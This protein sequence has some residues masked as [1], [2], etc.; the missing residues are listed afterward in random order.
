MVKTFIIDSQGNLI[1]ASKVW[2]DFAATIP[3]IR[4]FSLGSNFPPQYPLF[5]GFP[6]KYHFVFYAFVGFFEK[7]GF[8]LDWALNIPSTISFFVLLILIYVF[9]KKV[10]QKREVGILAIILFLFNGSLSFI[11]FF[12]INPLSINSFSDIISNSKFPSFAPYD[13]KIITAFWNLNIY[14]NQRHLA[15]SFLGFLLLTLIIF[16]SNK[17]ADNKNLKIYLVGFFVGIFPFVHLAVFGAMSIA[18]LIFFLIYPKIR[19]QLFISGL[20]TIIIAVPQLLYMKSSIISIEFLNPGFLIEEL[21]FGNF[22][23]YWFLNLGAYIILIPLSL[24]FINKE[25]R[26]IFIPFMSLFI[27]ANF[28][29][30]SREIA[31]NHKLFNIFLIGGNILVANLLVNIHSKN[32]LG[33]IIVFILFPFLILSGLIDLFPILND[34][35]LKI[36]DYPKDKRIDFINEYTPKDSVFLNTQ[37]LYDPASLAGRKIYLGW[38]YFSWSAGYYTN[39]RHSLM[40][41]MFSA[42]DEEAL[43]SL[44]I[45]ENIDYIEIQ[46]PNGLEEVNINYSY[47][48]ENFARIYHDKEIN[49]AIYDVGISCNNVK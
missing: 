33:K 43:C 45:G 37:F 1:I 11:E 34:K 4:S 49:Y 38:P 10:F 18:L 15:F 9:S 26:K 16:L 48:R 5:P 20:I 31:A 14:T 23:Y 13:G 35:H 27:V 30:F 21:N 42:T 47:F 28:F 32:L 40:K 7:I 19:K 41:E 8:P 3:L 44:L 22:L 25:Q 2:S 39:K 12:K 46:N 6:I 36:S 17:S 24:V 29:Q